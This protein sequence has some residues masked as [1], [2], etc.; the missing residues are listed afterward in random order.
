MKE[1][2]IRPAAQVTAL[3]AVLAGIAVA[4][5]AQAPEIKRYMQLRSM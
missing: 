5:A 1:I 2:C 3:L 4:L